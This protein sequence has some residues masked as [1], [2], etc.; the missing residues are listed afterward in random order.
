MDNLAEEFYQS[1][2]SGDRS[3]EA[4]GR[5]DCKQK[6]NG[7]QTSCKQPVFSGTPADTLFLSRGRCARYSLGAPHADHGI[8][9]RL[10]GV[11]Q[12]VH[13]VGSGA[14]LA[15]RPPLPG[16]YPEGRPPP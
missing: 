6:P 15:R 5:R 16:C 2:M 3:I 8:C 10:P 9:C 7:P 11:P 4:L 12:G 14:P 1:L 13:F